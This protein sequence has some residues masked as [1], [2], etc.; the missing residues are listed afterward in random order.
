MLIGL[1]DHC[2]AVPFGD[3]ERPNDWDCQMALGRYHLQ[4]PANNSTAQIDI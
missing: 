4:R 1:A 3:F 2:G